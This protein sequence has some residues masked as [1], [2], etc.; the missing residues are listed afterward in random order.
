MDPISSRILLGAGG[1]GND[2]YSGTI[3]IAGNGA[4]EF[5]ESTGFGTASYPST[6]VP[7]VPRGVAVH[8]S[9]NYVAVGG[10]G[11]PY[12]RSYTIV[13]G[14]FGTSAQGV[15]SGYINSAYKLAWNSAGTALLIG[16]TSY[17]YATIFGFNA[18]TNTY[19]TARY[20]PPSTYISGDAYSVDWH[21]TGSYVALGT[22]SSPYIN[23]YAISGT[24]WGSKS[25][26]P[27]TL[28]AN[29]V[30]GIK[31]SPNGQYIALAEQSGYV[32]VYGFSSG[33]IGTRY[34]QS[35]GSTVRDVDWSPDGTQ[36]VVAVS[37]AYPYVEAYPWNNPG[38]GTKYTGPSPAP[39]NIGN[40]ARTAKFTP[41]GNAVILGGDGS[42]L[43]AY[44]W[45]ATGWGTKYT[46]GS[47]NTSKDLSFTP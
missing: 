39:T 30:N 10:I 35:C 9:G 21:P 29:V 41:A 16:H 45:S 8:P 38:F 27:S 15:G 28:P 17:P 44:E 11:S 34:S 18:A 3:F 19:D 6:A 2:A 24:A 42:D 22:G 43:N 37:N 12:V 14:T 40:I 23:V 7:A 47:V 20:T 32:S 4:I 5:D 25:S 33:V 1:A 31:F 26:N 46:N 13:G 36:L